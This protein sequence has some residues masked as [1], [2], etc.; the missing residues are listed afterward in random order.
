[1]VEALASLVV[2]DPDASLEVNVAAMADAAA[3]VR[4]G[5]VT[6]AVR[7]SVAECGEIKMGDWIA[8][9]REGICAST[10]SAAE[11]AI[12]L[13]DQLVDEDSELVTVLIGSD[14]RPAD[15]ARLREH[16]G[17]EHGHVEVEVHE[18][19]QP[20]YPYLIGVE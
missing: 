6:Q 9:T 20:L 8:I 15:T 1:V 12:A 18:G 19:D 2:Y 11:A 13:V 4:A 7:D 3:R 14:A 17:L 10:A 5:E 16:L